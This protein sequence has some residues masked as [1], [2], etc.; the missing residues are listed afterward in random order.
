[1]VPNIPEW[2]QTFPQW[3]RIFPE[4]CQMFPEW[5]QMFPE[6]Q[7]MDEMAE[8]QRMEK[9]LKADSRRRKNLVDQAAFTRLL[10]QMTPRITPHRSVSAIRSTPQINSTPIRFNSTWPGKPRPSLELNHPKR[11]FA[12]LWKVSIERVVRDP[13]LFYPCATSPNS[14]TSS[15]PTLAETEQLKQAHTDT[16]VRETATRV[17]KLSDNTPVR[18]N[19]YIPRNS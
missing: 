4:W 18:V 8:E 2:C 10:T 7:G 9:Q 1:M 6:P 19:V 16:V 5:C 13:A 15:L 11:D 12:K 14:S 3:C 17:Q